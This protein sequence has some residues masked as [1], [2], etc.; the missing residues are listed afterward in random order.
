MRAKPPGL[1]KKRMENEKFGKGAAKNQEG[2]FPF[3]FSGLPGVRGA[4]PLAPTFPFLRW[5]PNLGLPGTEVREDHPSAM[6]GRAQRLKKNKV[7]K[8]KIVRFM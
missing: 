5:S 3:G 8:L 6:T 7:I 4:E 1:G 2:V